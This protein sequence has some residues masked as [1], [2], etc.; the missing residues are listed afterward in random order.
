MGTVMNPHGSVGILWRFLNGCEIK[1]KRTKHAINVEFLLEFH[2]RHSSCNLCYW[3][4]SSL[5]LVNTHSRGLTP[6][7]VQHIKNASHE[8]THV[9]SIEDFVVL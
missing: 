6:L 2:Q 4:F 5:S 8:K 9:M 3:P 7:R 1:R